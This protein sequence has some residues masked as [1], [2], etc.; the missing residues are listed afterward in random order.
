MSARERRDLEDDDGGSDVPS[1]SISRTRDDGLDDDPATS[2]GGGRGNRPGSSTPGSRDRDD[3]DDNSRARDAARNDSQA[4]QR[5]GGS[6]DPTDSDTRTDAFEAD[7]DASRRVGGS[8]DPSDEPEPDTVDVGGAA[9]SGQGPR[10]GI[11]DR[12]P[13]RDVRATA[14]LD[15]QTVTDLSLD[16]VQIDGDRATLTPD[17]VAAE[18]EALEAAQQEQRQQQQTERFGDLDF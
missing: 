11:S 16:D 15:T 8:G 17:A 13:F 14:Q 12:S 9:D 18:R 1:S 4:S 2:G 5:V 10:V 3:D 7:Q 6:G